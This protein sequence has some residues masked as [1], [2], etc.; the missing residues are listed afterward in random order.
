[1]YVTI[2]GIYYTHCNVV[3]EQV[4]CDYHDRS[5]GHIYHLSEITSDAGIYNV[6]SDIYLIGGVY[7]LQ[8]RQIIR[9]LCPKSP[10]TPKKANSLITKLLMY[11]QSVDSRVHAALLSCTERFTC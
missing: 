6:S 5:S 7:T 10:I 3:K 8:H 4:N 2:V 11:Y 1:M 9:F